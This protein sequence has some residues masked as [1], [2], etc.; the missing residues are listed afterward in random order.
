MVFGF[1]LGI[2]SW[3]VCYDSGFW[4]G[5]ALVDVGGVIERE[6]GSDRKCCI[7]LLYNLYYFNVLYVKIK[8]EMLSI[9]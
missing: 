2:G 9:L 6:R 1:F 7:I 3:W 4:C 5:G 8:I